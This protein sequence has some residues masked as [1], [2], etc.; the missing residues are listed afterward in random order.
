MK[1]KRYLIPE[2]YH[3]D[4]SVHVFNGKLHVYPSHDW[5][6][7]DTENDNGDQYDMKDYH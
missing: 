6:C 1:E 7:T 4:P 2:D 5:D 3:A